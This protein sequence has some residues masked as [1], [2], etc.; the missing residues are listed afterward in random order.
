MGQPE[1]AVETWGH[2]AIVTEDGVKVFGPATIAQAEEKRDALVRKAK[3]KKRKC[4]SCPEEIM[5]EGPHHRM[6]ARC[7]NVSASAELI[8]V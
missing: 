2:Q 5:S 3:R 8:A 6:C 7:R 4:I 1:F